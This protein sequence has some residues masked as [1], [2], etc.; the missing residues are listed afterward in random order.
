MPANQLRLRVVN[1]QS[2]VSTKSPVSSAQWSVQDPDAPVV[3]RA[4]AGDRQ[5]FDLLVLK[6]HTK[7]TSLAER[8]MKNHAD[9]LDVAQDALVR[10]WRAIEKFR[11]DSRFYTW[12]YRITI[13]T[14]KNALAAKKRKPAMNIDLQ[15]KLQS[16]EMQSKL[17]HMD[18]PEAL[19]NA[20]NIKTTVLEA[21]EA[22]PTDLRT[23]IELRELEGLSYDAIAQTMGC[24]IGTVRSRIFRA[25]E[26]VSQRLVG[27]V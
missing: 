16:Y 9:A 14:A 25:R 22:L 15:D 7:L 1:P 5:A 8:Y 2:A 10:A 12:L 17:T 6:Y 24:P 13:N 21:I 20:D 23:A 18:T 4:Q 19:I 27:L 3:A 11:G 26:A